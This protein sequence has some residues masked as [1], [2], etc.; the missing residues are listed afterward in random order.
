MFNKKMA[1]GVLSTVLV[2]SLIAG[3]GSSKPADSAQSSG[4][5]AASAKPAGKALEI[6]LAH[7]GSDTHQYHI[8]ALA[9]E[10]ALEAK[11]NKTIDVKIYDNAKL[12]SEKDAVEGVIDGE[13]GKELLAK[14]DAK[15]MKGLGLLY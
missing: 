9:F 13:I 7:S 12:G 14:A 1:F 11:S 15:G 10:K 2:A 6:K 5:V 8:A 3:C 4:S